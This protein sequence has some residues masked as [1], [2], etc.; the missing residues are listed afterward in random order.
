MNSP[1]PPHHDAADVVI[2][3]EAEATRLALAS[4]LA[5]RFR[6][7]HGAPDT[8]ADVVSSG[9]PQVLVLG[10]SFA[11]DQALKAVE[12][13]NVAM[14]GLMT[15]LVAPSTDTNLMRSAL[16]A[17]LREVMSVD[18]V[19]TQLRGTVERFVAR[20]ASRPTDGDATELGRPGE[21]I[22]VVAAKGGVGVTTVAVNLA[23]EIARQGRTVALVD[24]DVQFGDVAICMA[25]RPQGTLLSAVQEGPRL[26]T[27]R[28]R[29]MM[30]RH[31]PSGVMVLPGA[32]DPVAADLIRPAEV[33]NVIEIA[34]RI[35]EVVVV[36]VP[37]GLDDLALA[38]LDTS[39]RIALVTTPAL[40]NLK[41][42]R[43]E[44]GV[45]SKLHVAAKTKVVV[46]RA[47]PHHRVSRRTVEHHLG[48]EVIGEVPEADDVAIAETSRTPFT[49][50]AR[51]S[52]PAKAIQGI[53]A[54]IAPAPVPSAPAQPLIGTR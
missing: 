16:E 44:I 40:A 52:Q 17:G 36:D 42:A 7:A 46:N 10:P 24:A 43:L 5:G 9:Q 11:N 2:I 15:V 32:E 39:D 18:E 29:S 22:A 30:T 37:A 20:V 34:S 21:V 51:R 26:N 33:A 28:L 48:L 19:P 45:L 25:L 4:Q 8:L 13:A 6:V 27:R 49:L 3:D 50:A 53:C 12:T 14:A 38:I 35:A 41:N 31:E 1:N 23:V 47:D 54:V